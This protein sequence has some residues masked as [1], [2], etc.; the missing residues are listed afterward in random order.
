[1]FVHDPVLLGW[2]N[3]EGR[4]GQGVCNLQ[5]KLYSISIKLQGDAY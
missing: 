3:S 4:G 2:L 5:I 1:M